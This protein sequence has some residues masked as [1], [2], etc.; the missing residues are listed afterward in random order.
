VNARVSRKLKKEAR[1]AFG[2]AHREAWLA[3]CTAPLWR[4][5][6]LAMR[7]ATGRPFGVWRKRRTKK[8]VG[9]VG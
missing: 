2:E 9:Y 5:L 1:A 4:R 6:V 3:V 7:L 8:E